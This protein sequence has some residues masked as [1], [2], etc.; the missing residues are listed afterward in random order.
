MRQMVFILLI[1]LLAFAVAC[2]TA[3][4]RYDGDDINGDDD[5]PSGDDD[6]S[7][8]DD[9][10]PEI[11]NFT[12]VDADGNE[13]KLYDLI[14]N[15][16]L[17]TAGAFWCQPCKEEAPSLQDDIWEKFK[18]DDFVLISLIVQDAAYNDATQQ[19]AA[20]WRDDFGLGFTVCADPD[21]SLQPYFEKDVIPFNLLLDRDFQ[22]EFSTHEYNKDVM[23]FLIEDL[24]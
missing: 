2:G 9:V 24:L 19:T 17:L 1:V 13:V 12:W 7:D 14:G 18:D 22:I 20:D 21:W 16:V 15:V 4:G 10:Q 3:K 23:T 6:A 8:D 11:A 5:A